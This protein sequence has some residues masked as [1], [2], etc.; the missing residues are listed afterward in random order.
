MELRLDAVTRRFGDVVA[1]DALSMAV[2]PGEVVG[3]LG[4]NGAGKTTTVRLLA[5]L[6][7]P[8]AGT[9]RVGRLDP[10][11][12]GAAVRQ[13]LGVLPARP[14]VDDRLTAAQNLRFAADVF[15]LPHD[16][17]S[18]RIEAALAA[19]DLAERAGERVGDFSTGMRQR[20][21]LARVLFPDPEILLLDEP[22]AALDPIAARQ[23][24][25]AL[26]TL[27]RDG[28]RT[29]VLCTHDLAEAESLC[30]RVVV[31]ANGAIVAQGSPAEL[32]AHH[33]QGGLLVEVAADEVGV[34]QR[35]L[36]PI[37]HGD[38]EVEGAGRVRATGV[39]RA[40]VPAFVSDLVD[41]R[42]TVF[43]I[44]RLEPSLEDVYLALHGQVP[45]ERP[46]DREVR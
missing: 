23:V 41:R 20:L 26:A 19:F 37:A 1:L 24:R 46:T 7:A 15:G 18:Q 5:G 44:R 22:T 17:L 3:L 40:A 42:V 9:V 11:A 31:L 10:L 4:H 12:D 38:V 14:V 34:V 16:G 2:A 27:A 43:E 36:T 39:A 21:S 28:R 33:G 32:A 35:L 45:H 8:D 6:L 30:D 29:V 13:R 25:R